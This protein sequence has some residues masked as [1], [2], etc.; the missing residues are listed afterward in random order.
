[1]NQKPGYKTTEFWITA[2]VNIAAAIIAILAARGL[3]KSVEGSLY[4]AL[5]QALAVTVAPLVMA[6][7]TAKY[8]EGRSL[9]KAA[10]NKVS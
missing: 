1:M 6:I 3:I 2:A 10:N 9:V 7:V 4:L 8:V 5:V